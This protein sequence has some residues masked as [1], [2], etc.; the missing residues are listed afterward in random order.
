M[1]TKKSKGLGR[2]LEALLGGSSDITEM[3]NNAPGA[4][5]EMALDALQ[6]GKYQPR[7]RMDEGALNELADSIREQGVL[8]PI[9]VRPVAA[10]NG[11]ARYEIIAGERRFRAAK[12]AGLDT[13]PVIV[14]EADDKRT[15]AIA[16]I[17]NLQ[18]EDLNPLEEAQG[19]HRLLQEFNFTHE[20]AAVAVSRS[21]SAVSNLLRLIN[22]T[23][24]VQTMLMA[25]D[26]DMGHARALLAVDAGSQITLA[27]QIVAKRMSVREAEKL[28]TRAIAE[29]AAGGKPREGG[30]KEKSRDIAR[31]EEELSDLL[32]TQVVLKTGARNKG[33]L[34][35][36]FAN[37]DALDDVIARLKG[38]A[39]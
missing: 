22:L 14:T 18:R 27:N 37:L 23:K 12:L 26:I 32:A 1:A 35:I 20:Q 2:G 36:N 4:M 8:Q 28:V 5:C 16:L 17:E 3:A 9:L 29:Q 31:L 39:E 19:I 13:V 34:I 7:T 30:G 24:P 38:G 15:A 25:G 6:A 21:R 11:H 10:H 33:Q